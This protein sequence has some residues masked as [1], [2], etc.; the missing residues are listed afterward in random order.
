MLQSTS[1]HH[2][3]IMLLLLAMLCATPVSAQPLDVQ[4]VPAIPEADAAAV[5]FLPGP[6]AVRDFSS[7]TEWLDAQIREKSIPG[8]A[9]AIVRSGSVLDIQTWGV[10]TLDGA[11]PIDSETVFRIASVSKTF[12]GTVAAKLV[13]HQ[14]QS[15]DTPLVTVLPQY[16]IGTGPETREITLRH[17][18]SHTTGL[19]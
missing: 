3:R 15:W 2:R 8:V 14:Q 4:I 7:Y 16:V 6:A 12:A 10:R 19:M 13:Q 18:L 5:E 1:Q 11:E 9:M 17:V